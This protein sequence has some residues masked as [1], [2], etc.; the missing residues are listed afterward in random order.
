LELGPVELFK[1]NNSK[2]V[3]VVGFEST[4]HVLQFAFFDLMGNVFEQNYLK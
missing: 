2:G 4:L 1:E 3:G